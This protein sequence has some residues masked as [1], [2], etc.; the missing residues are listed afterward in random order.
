MCI[1]DPKRDLASDFVVVGDLYG[2][3]S[4]EV[5]LNVGR[6]A[7]ILWRSC[8]CLSGKLGKVSGKECNS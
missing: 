8:T 7:L 6:V 5:D 2:V 4:V 1:V 3:E